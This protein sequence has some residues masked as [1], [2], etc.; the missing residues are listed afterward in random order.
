NIRSE[1]V[2]PPTPIRVRIFLQIFHADVVCTPP[3]EIGALL[4][5]FLYKAGTR[6]DGQRTFATLRDDIPSTK[7]SVLLAAPRPVDRYD[8]AWE[9]R[10]PSRST[11]GP[12]ARHSFRLRRLW[13]WTSCIPCVV[14]LMCI[15]HASPPVSAVC[16]RMAT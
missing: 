10:I 4:G 9:E 13:L 14:A 12:E 6:D 8:H 2:A 7:R 15:R 5:I 3:H 16:R 1:R 11:V